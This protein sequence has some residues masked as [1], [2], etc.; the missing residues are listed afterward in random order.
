[1]SGSVLAVLLWSAGLGLALAL[2]LAL[3][4]PLSVVVEV[5]CCGE[6]LDIDAVTRSLDRLAQD[7]ASLRELHDHALAADWVSSVQTRLESLE[8]ARIVLRVH[9]PEVRL[10]DGGMISAS[11][12]IF[13]TA[14]TP[15]DLPLL[16]TLPGD[17]VLE[18]H[19]IF[20]QLRSLGRSAGWGELGRLRR[21]RLEG[22]RAEFDSGLR[23]VFGVGDP[24]VK[25]A[26]LHRFASLDLER[27]APEE[28][29]LDYDRAMA[30]RPAPQQGG[31]P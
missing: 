7:G 2:W 16:I 15:Q 4:P 5:E 31:A 21:D 18:Q 25:L 17:D 14:E 6:R 27:L 26:R 1:M 24:A 13:R 19:R 23:I 12:R 30:V 11:G 10:A 9:R 29:R 22:L 3:H 8:R 28:I 20:R